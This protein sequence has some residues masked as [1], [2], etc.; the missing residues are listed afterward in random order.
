M[1]RSSVGLKHGSVNIEVL[2]SNLLFVPTAVHTLHATIKLN[3]NNCLTSKWLYRHCAGLGASQSCLETFRIFLMMLSYHATNRQAG[4]W[5]S[6]SRSLLQ[7]SIRPVRL[8]CSQ[9]LLL[10]WLKCKERE[11]MSWDS[12]KD[13]ISLRSSWWG[14]EYEALIPCLI[15]IY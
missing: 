5:C 15:Q 1:K 11:I 9:T 4:L 10:H 3:R 12:G 7:G 13:W 6:L 14:K 2:S 8:L